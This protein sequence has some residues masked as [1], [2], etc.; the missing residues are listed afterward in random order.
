MGS[1]KSITRGGVGFSREASRADLRQGYGRPALYP[2]FEYRTFPIDLPRHVQ[3]FQRGGAQR[4]VPGLHVATAQ[5]TA[6]SRE[7]MTIAH[8]G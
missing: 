4:S 6:T 5:M 8:T 3:W 7:M 1:L 2:A